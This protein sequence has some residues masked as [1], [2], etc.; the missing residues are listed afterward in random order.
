LYAPPSRHDK[1]RDATD[2]NAAR[3]FVIVIEGSNDVRDESG[4]AQTLSALTQNKFVK[5][6][7][8]S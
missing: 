2:A 6:S 3:R 4:L 1:P 8:F 7:F 5:D